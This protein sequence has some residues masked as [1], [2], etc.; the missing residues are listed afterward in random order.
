MKKRILFLISGVFASILP[1][2]TLTACGTVTES[3]TENIIA[4]FS[5]HLDVLEA[6][7][8]PVTGIADKGMG[9][10]VPYL[11]MKNIT[12]ENYINPFD[13]VDPIMLQELGNKYSVMVGSY[14]V[15]N[16]QK[17]SPYFEHYVDFKS[18]QNAEGDDAEQLT[19]KLSNNDSSSKNGI[20]YNGSHT[21]DV[22]DLYF[23]WLNLGKSLDEIYNTNKYEDRAI[24]LEKS[25]KQKIEKLR[26]EIQ[27]LPNKT[28][29]AYDW[30]GRTT[31]GGDVSTDFNDYSHFQNIYTPQGITGSLL[32]SKKNGLG[33][34][35]PKF[36]LSSDV[37]ASE[38]KWSSITSLSNGMRAVRNAALNEND[39]VLL[40]AQEYDK[41]I[42]NSSVQSAFGGMLKSP[43][44]M[45][46]GIS[47]HILW[48]KNISLG[49]ATYGPKGLNYTIDW[50]AQQLH[51]PD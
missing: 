31:P 50:I 44:K 35:A 28:L 17:I 9:S 3:S 4:A 14:G 6:L 24:A 15:S 42:S 1:L 36:N 25:T 5:N 47:D 7:G 29:L 34:D 33:F 49:V 39:F 10:K 48:N 30:G 32:Y 41:T 40:D 11:D 46:D 26:S 43:G 22:S 2:S 19:W 51:L 38:G 13:S 21:Y 23:N 16:S 8:A 27:K 12:Q 45:V 20:T 37:V 18:T